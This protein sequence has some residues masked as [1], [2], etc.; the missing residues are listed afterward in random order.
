MTFLVD[1]L[2]W[3]GAALLLLAYFRVSTGRTAGKSAGYQA[4]N[5]IG[6][7]L[8]GGNALYYRALPSF[9]VNV[10]WITIAL[11]TLARTRDGSRSDAG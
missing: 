8:V 11:V 1:V 6:S 2:G 5:V 10:V 4:L 7:V 3:I 9:T